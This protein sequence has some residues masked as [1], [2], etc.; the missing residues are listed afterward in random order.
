MLYANLYQPGDNQPFATLLSQPGKL[1][2]SGDAD[3]VLALLDEA[4]IDPT[5]DRSRVLTFADGDDYV[6][7]VPFALRDPFIRVEVVDTDAILADN[8]E[9]VETFHHPGGK[10]HNQKNHT[11][12]GYIRKNP[13]L[14]NN[15]DA[16]IIKKDTVSAGASNYTKKQKAAAQT[17]IDDH[18]ANAAAAKA[19]GDTIDE[20]FNKDMAN[21]YKTQKDKAGAQGKAT[22]GKSYFSEQGKGKLVAVGAHG[23]WG[24]LEIEQVPYD[25]AGA[26]GNVRVGKKVIVDFEKIG[27]ENAK[28]TPGGK[29]IGSERDKKAAAAVKKEA[30]LQKKIDKAIAAGA[31]P[32]TLTDQLNKVKY[33]P[34]ST[35]K[36]GLKPGGTNWNPHWQKNFVD[37]LTNDEISS[38]G[39]YT[40]NGYSAINNGLRYPPPSESVKRHADNISSAMAKGGG[41]PSNFTVYRGSSFEGHAN[42]KPGDIF[43][44]AGFT[45]TSVSKSQKF[46]GNISYEIRVPK[47]AK[48]AYVKPISS[49]K[50]ENEFLIDKGARFKVVEATT[51]GSPYSYY[52]THHYVV[53]L[54]LD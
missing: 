22:L 26:K 4:V 21:F 35:S 18:L 9:D 6:R 10:P 53:E 42:M 33:G 36:A 11:R 31:D 43:S 8:D 5:G 40:A 12:H 15:V 14:A 49:V 7:A 51:N 37:K 13:K 29:S 44:D 3:R 20:D 25:K 2:F 27:V 52:K 19:A 16:K 17:H 41:A 38:I 47:G 45:S 39:N 50:K 54:L 30:N 48:G 34:T 1:E 28:A 32:S 46:S 24:V 23:T